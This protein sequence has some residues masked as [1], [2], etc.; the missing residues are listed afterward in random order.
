[1]V[2]LAHDYFMIELQKARTEVNMYGS[3]EKMSASLPG[4]TEYRF[5]QF[6]EVEAILELLNIQLRRIRGERF[7]HY[8]ESYNRDLTTRDAEKYADSDSK[9][10]DFSEVVN[11]FALVR[12]RYAGVLKGLE[13]QGYQINNI[14]RLRA[15]GMEDAFLSE[16][17]VPE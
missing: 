14:T 8:L 12:N 11:L 9:V 17:H 16:V 4:I 15:A 7:R 1:M 13:T 3:I 5:A 6:Q 2:L 10:L